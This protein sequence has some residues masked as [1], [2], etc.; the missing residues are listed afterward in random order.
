MAEAEFMPLLGEGFVSQCVREQTGAGAE[1]SLSDRVDYTHT[2]TP[3]E[4][5]GWV[6][7]QKYLP[8][9]LFP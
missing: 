2:Q 7:W 1:G 3:L 6:K 8:F 9:S 4:M 5:L